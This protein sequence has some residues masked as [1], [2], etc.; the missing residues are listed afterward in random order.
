M[1]QE[2]NNTYIRAAKKDLMLSDKSVYCEKCGEK[3]DPLMEFC[4]NCGQ[5]I[6]DNT[7][8]INQEKAGNFNKK[9]FFAGALATVLAVGAAIGISSIVTNNIN[10]K[11]IFYTKED[12]QIYFRDVSKDESYQISVSNDEEVALF[13]P[14]NIEKDIIV[15]ENGKYIFFPESKRANDNEFL[16][17]SIEADNPNDSLISIGSVYENS[18][19]CVNEA[20]GIVTYLDDNT[21]YQYNMKEKKAIDDYVNEFFVSQDCK[22]IF[23]L[24][25]G[26]ELYGW[27]DNSGS[28]IIDSDVDWILKTNEDL[29]E[30]YYIKG[31]DVYLYSD[32]SLSCRNIIN[33]CDNHN[34]WIADDDNIFFM[35]T[36]KKQNLMLDFVNDDMADTDSAVLDYPDRPTRVYRSDF[37]TEE[38]YQDAK[39]KYEEE[40]NIYNTAVDDYVEKINRDILREKMAETYFTYITYDIYHYFDGVETLIAENIGTEL[41]YMEPYYMAKDAPV[42]AFLGYDLPDNDCKIVNLSEISSTSDFNT[43]FENLLLEYRVCYL[44]TNTNYKKIKDVSFFDI[45]SLGTIAYFGVNNQ[46]YKEENYV[47]LYRINIDDGYI[48][49]PILYKEKISYGRGFL[50]NGDYIYQGE[51]EI[52]YINDISLGQY[53]QEIIMSNDNKSIY[54]LSDYQQERFGTGHWLRYGTLNFMKN[55]EIQTIARD[56]LDFEVINGEEVVYLQFNDNNI[57]V[58]TLYYKNNGEIEVLDNNVTNI[59]HV[60]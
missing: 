4:P 34:I 39:E 37:E 23:Y 47:D 2:K 57:G 30:I 50:S 31:N 52:T 16:L 29:T 60:S 18:K 48:N 36:N 56:I 43:K 12:G 15:S 45:N 35:R 54:Y 55:N 42:C 20:G 49:D 53:A 27:K 1:D 59:F 32:E 10:N 28:S 26:G 25:G 22:K 33:N 9:R 21:L 13:Y 3:L 51:D 8:N 24:T 58:G 14:E 17:C 41:N 7:Y 46:N 44:V 38:Q 19:I 5:K 11:Y 40:L 6:I